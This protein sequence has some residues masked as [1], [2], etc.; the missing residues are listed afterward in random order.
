MAKKNIDISGQ[1]FLDGRKA[2]A[3][4][5]MPPMEPDWVKNPPPCPPAKK[6][7][8]NISPKTGEWVHPAD[9]FIDVDWKTGKPLAPKRAP[10]KAKA[11]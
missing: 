4:R 10:R 8:L 11:K 5:P 2:D 7:I 1:T 6:R 3:P 9:T